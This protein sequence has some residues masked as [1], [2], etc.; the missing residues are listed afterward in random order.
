VV[1]EAGTL[2][3]GEVVEHKEGAEVAELCGLNLKI[4][5]PTVFPITDMSVPRAIRQAFLAIEQAEDGEVV[6]HKEGAEV[7][8]LCGS[9]GAAH[10][11]T[12]AFCLLKSVT[13]PSDKKH[14]QSDKPP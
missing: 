6:E 14:C 2:T 3:D 10:T 12:C 5:T 9:N 8:E 11:S 1:R 4:P 7:A 13:V